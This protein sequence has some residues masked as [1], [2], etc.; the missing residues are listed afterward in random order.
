MRRTRSGQIKS[1]F[2]VISVLATLS[3]FSCAGLFGVDE[4]R[5][6]YE[7][8]LFFFNQGRFSDAIPSFQQ[9]IQLD[10]NF[11]EPHLYLGRSYLNLH[12]Y[13]NSIPALK[14]AFRISPRTFQKEIADLLIDALL[15]QASYELD[16]G[17]IQASLQYIREIIEA[18][19]KSK[20]I[21]EDTSNVIAAI[22]WELYRS[23]KAKDAIKEYGDAIRVNPENLSAYVGLA[24]ALW[25][26]G[27]LVKA[28]EAAEKAISLDPDSKEALNV[29]KGLLK[30]K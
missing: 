16:Q 4:A 12:D 11:Y 10:D 8:G 2:V 1:L 23:G 14:K 18:D 17:N 15:G 7:Q 19:P 28:I 21:K 27:E 5:K 6:S 29:I 13:Q 30:T 20:K 26:N 25:K 3:M 22:A 24:R 9:A